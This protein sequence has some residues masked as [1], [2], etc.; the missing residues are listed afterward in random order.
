MPL[1]R[2]RYV[3]DAVAAVAADTPEIAE[4]ALDLIEVEYEELPG[5]FDPEYGASPEAPLIHPDLASYE[6]VPFIF[7]QPGTNIS[8]WFKVRKGDMERGWAEADLVYEHKYQVPHIQHV[9]LETARLRGSAGCERQDHA[10]VLQP[11]AVCA[12][13][14]D[15]QGAAHRPQQAARDHAARRRRLRLARPA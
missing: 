5:V 9:P 7:P 8:N 10:V 6:C 14:P 11:V 12:A 4:Q 2:V 1:D 13:Q 3:G 15:R